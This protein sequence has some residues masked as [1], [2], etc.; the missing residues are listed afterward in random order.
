[1]IGASEKLTRADKAFCRRW[2]KAYDKGQ[3]TREITLDWLRDLERPV[4]VNK[5][6]VRPLPTY[7]YLACSSIATFSMPAHLS[8]PGIMRINLTGTL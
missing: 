7:R 6:L 2:K 1:M 3:P 8:P 5:P 4:P